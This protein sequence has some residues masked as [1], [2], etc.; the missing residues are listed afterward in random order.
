MQ[1]NLKSMAKD[2][3]A[4][5]T[6]LERVQARSESASN[7]RLA[8][9]QRELDETNAQWQSQAPYV[10]EHL[11]EVDETRLNNL[12]D[13]LTQFQ[14]HEVDLVEQ[15]RKTAEHCLNVLLQVETADEI[16][17]FAIKAVSSQ[18]RP[19][20]TTGA[21]T[22]PAH[23]AGTFSP[24]MLG[25]SSSIPDD[26]SQRSGSVQEDKKKN[27]FSA[28][29][30]M[31][32]TF[33]RRNK[34]ESKLPETMSS[35][36]GSEKK[37]R[38]G[39][40][41]LG[42]RNRSKPSVPQLETSPEEEDFGAIDNASQRPSMPP[43]IGSEVLDMPGRHHYATPTPAGRS[44]IPPNIN[45]SAMRTVNGSHQGDLADLDSPRPLRDV[46]EGLRSTP[47]EPTR[48]S[49]GYSMPP[50]ELDPISAAQQQ[51]EADGETALPA[52]NVNIRDT[53]VQDGVAGSDDV[54]ATIANKLVSASDD[55]WYCAALTYSC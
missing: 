22:T 2:V 14:T 43:Q 42:R 17:T 29:T 24:G 34:R 30:R 1:G 20:R 54:L 44:E 38:P 21:F 25:P 3:D 32:T 40:F 7:S 45:G 8:D 51:A 39:P 52:F 31:G 48:D 49:E 18:P 16:K 19:Q 37:S 41:S 12:R 28:I 55:Y 47:P 10:F 5:Q 11:Q 50:R 6:K 33:G 4:A 23:G 27:R 35:A 46:P 53:P 9:A 26:V 15:N 36:E 13:V